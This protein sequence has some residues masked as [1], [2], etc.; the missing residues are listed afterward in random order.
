MNQNPLMTDEAIVA[1]LFYVAAEIGVVTVQ[2]G[3]AVISGTLMTPE[4][5]PRSTT[6][7]SN[8]CG[9]NSGLHSS[10]PEASPPIR[11]ATPSVAF[12]PGASTSAAPWNR[13]RASRTLR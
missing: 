10:S 7:P 1:H 4:A 2:V 6:A 8:T 13:R 11:S 12:A 3:R 9:R 5:E